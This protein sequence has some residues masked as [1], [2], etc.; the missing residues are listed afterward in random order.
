MEDED[1][2]EYCTTLDE[3]LTR[4]TP[5]GFSGAVLVAKNENIFLNRGYGM[6]VKDKGIV[7]TEKTVFGIGS[8]TK[9]FTAA[10]VLKLEMDGKLNTKDVLG[11]Y[12]DTPKDKSGITI[13][14]LLTHNSHN[15]TRWEY[16][17][18][19]TLGK[20]SCHRYEDSRKSCHVRESSLRCTIC[21]IS[22]GHGKKYRH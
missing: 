3:Y 22:F 7:N 11:E 18:G 1:K 12:L 10:A 4:I 21:G 17:T 20:R 6:A 9:Q 16:N 19:V 13:H 5:F 2:I 15:C 14:H 8:V